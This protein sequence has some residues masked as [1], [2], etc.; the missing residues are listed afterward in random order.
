MANALALPKSI[1][2]WTQ[3][4]DLTDAAAAAAG[5][6]AATVL[7]TMLV[8]NT[9]NITG[10]ALRIGAGVL[11]AGAAGS[12]GSAMFNSK[13]GKAAAIGA[14]AGVV[15]QLITMLGIVK[16]GGANPVSR[17]VGRIADADIIS[18]PSARSEET[19]NMIFP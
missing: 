15:T 18:M 17:A 7:P 10:K 13:V 8:K 3:G 2:Q 1:R 14:M 12:I 4:V 19:V 16:L 6:V 9:S 5:L 11:A